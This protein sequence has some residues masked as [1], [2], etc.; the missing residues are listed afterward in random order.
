VSLD[1]LGFKMLPKLMMPRE[2]FESLPDTSGDDAPGALRK[3]LILRRWYAIEPHAE[4]GGQVEF[5]RPI[6]IGIFVRED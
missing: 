2:I 5:A 3:A 6:E 1:Q 4:F